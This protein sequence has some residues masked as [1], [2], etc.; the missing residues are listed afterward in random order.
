MLTVAQLLEQLPEDERLRFLKAI[1]A[2][3]HA[4]RM[5][6]QSVTD[7]G[8]KGQNVVQL[9]HYLTEAIERLEEARAIVR[10]YA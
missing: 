7:P 1:G 8:P 9:A 4:A 3:L 2:G 10:R 5:A 6:A